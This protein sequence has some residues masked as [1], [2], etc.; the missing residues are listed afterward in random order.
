MK[1]SSCEELSRELEEMWRPR[2][3]L[4]TPKG[5]QVLVPRLSHAVNGYPLI[6]SRK[7]K[8]EAAPELLRVQ[9]DV[10]ARQSAGC[11]VAVRE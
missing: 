5:Q 3:T 8:G 1:A 4:G 11:A 6:E 7:S 9:L 2:E 10:A